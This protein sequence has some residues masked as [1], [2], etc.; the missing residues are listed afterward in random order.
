MVFRGKKSAKFNVT[1]IMK[2]PILQQLDLPNL[3]TLAGLILSVTSAILAIQG[4]FYIAIVCMIY[5]GLTDMLDG[6]VARKMQRTHLQSEIG[7]QLD[8]IVDVCSFGFAPVIFAHCF[9][10]QDFLSVSV[11]MFYASMNALRLSYFNSVGLISEADEKY[12]TGLPVTY[13]AVFI[14][15]TFT[16]SLI[17]SD[18]MMKWVLDGVY[19]LLAIAMVSNFKMIKI[20]GIWYG[21][22]ALG[23]IA[24]TGFYSWII[25]LG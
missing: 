20:R 4:H 15:L 23:A 19:L 11:L 5:A 25:A 7:K 2:N 10:L 24:L 14:P 17:L 16:V 8:S 18:L 1:E 6:V 13:A 12:F 22:F 9:G 3:L 21:V